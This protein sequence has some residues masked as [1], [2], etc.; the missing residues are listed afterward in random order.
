MDLLLKRS[1]LFGIANLGRR[2]IAVK[3]IGLGL[4]SLGFG[5]WFLV[6]SPWFLVL[7]SFDFGLRFCPPPLG[8]G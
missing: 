5:L 7:G 3:G 2:C 6:L 4:W 8:R 1:E